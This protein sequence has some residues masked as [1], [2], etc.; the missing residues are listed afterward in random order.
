MTGKI[1]DYCKTLNNNDE[2]KHF[3]LTVTEKAQEKIKQALQEQKLEPGVA[4][5][6]I[7]SPLKP[8]TLVWTT[9]IEKEGDQVIKSKDGTKIL[10]I[11][12]DL[13]SEL[14]GMVLDYGKK[15]QGK[16]FIISCTNSKE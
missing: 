2:E 4:Y 5:R 1:I 10:L 3:M 8:N 15:A 6:I 9:D 14:E 12:P 16:G 13:V 11:D 7:S